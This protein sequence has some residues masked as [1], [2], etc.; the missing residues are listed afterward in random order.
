M[1]TFA[2]PVSVTV[3]VYIPTYTKTTG[4]NT[5]SKLRNFFAYKYLTQYRLFAFRSKRTDC[6][7]AVVLCMHGFKSFVALCTGDSNTTFW[8]ANGRK[9]PMRLLSFPTEI[10]PNFASLK[11]GHF[12]IFIVLGTELVFEILFWI[13]LFLS[14]NTLNK[15]SGRFFYNVYFAFLLHINT[16]CSMEY[17]SETSHM[18]HVTAHVSHS[19]L[20][21]GGKNT[22]D[23]LFRWSSYF[24]NAQTR[25]ER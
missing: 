17:V 22:A 19:A 15:T 18:L 20:I 21:E 1:E 10:S 23:C 14:H 25:Q 4:E 16:L 13:G 6:C 7:M 11:E 5:S 8:T 9:N 24:C 12:D 2:A 3:E